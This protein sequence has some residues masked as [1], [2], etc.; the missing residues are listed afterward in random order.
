MT[1]AGQYAVA[2]SAGGGYQISRRA[3]AL[4]PVTS[5]VETNRLGSNLARRKQAARTSPTYSRMAPCSPPSRTLRARG[6]LR[7]SLTAAVRGARRGSRSGQR[8]GPQSS[9]ET[10]GRLDTPRRN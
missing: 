6:G 2:T 5:R 1:S 10:F 9:K 4:Q 3:V 7:P 8:N